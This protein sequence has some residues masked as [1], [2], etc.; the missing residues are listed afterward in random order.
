MV[1][2]EMGTRP[3]RGVLSASESDGPSVDLVGGGGGG[4]GGGGWGGGGGGSR[5]GEDAAKDPAE[6]GGQDENL[7]QGMRWVPDSVNSVSLIVQAPR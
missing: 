1:S 2:A 5:G 6:G 4:G 3:A 7:G